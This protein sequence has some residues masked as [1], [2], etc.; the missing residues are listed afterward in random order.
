[1][2]CLGIF[3]Y[4]KPNVDHRWVPGST[5]STPFVGCYEYTIERKFEDLFQ[6]HVILKDN[7]TAFVVSLYE[8]RIYTDRPKNTINVFLH[9]IDWI[10][11]ECR[12]A[13]YLY[14]P[15]LRELLKLNYK[16]PKET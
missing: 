4:L 15:L 1:M 7:H 14:I 5:T 8:I 13:E 11:S 12:H 10:F 2:K 6:P 16:Q 9:E 3:G